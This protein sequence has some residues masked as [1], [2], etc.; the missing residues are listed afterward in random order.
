MRHDKSKT[1][2]NHNTNLTRFLIFRDLFSWIVPDLIKPTHACDALM[3]RCMKSPRFLGKSL[4]IQ[5][6]KTLDDLAMTAPQLRVSTLIAG[7]P[8]LVCSIEH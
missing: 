5:P 2:P 4:R 7:S 6:L 1:P 8:A 3:S